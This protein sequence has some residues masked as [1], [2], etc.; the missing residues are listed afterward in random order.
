MPSL[1]LAL[2]LLDSGAIAALMPKTLTVPAGKRLHVTGVTAVFTSSATV[3]N[4]TLALEVLDAA[5]VVVGRHVSGAVIA[6]S[7]TRYVNWGPGTHDTAFDVDSLAAK[8]PEVVL[9]PGWAIRLVDTADVDDTLDAA[10]LLI[11]GQ[12]QDV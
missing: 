10:R 12:L 4:R 3:G 2:N 9:E 5:P 6:A 7:V 8:M 11:S 1:K